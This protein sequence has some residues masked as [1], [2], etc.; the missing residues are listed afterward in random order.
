MG[1]IKARDFV[2]GTDSA[3]VWLKARE[4]AERFACSEGTLANLRAKRQ[5][6]PWAHLPGVGIRYALA[7]VLAFES[8]ARERVAA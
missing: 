8:S 7:D 2:S 3:A 6:V 1:D 5:G 4:L